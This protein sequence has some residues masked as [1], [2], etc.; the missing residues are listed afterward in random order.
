MRVQRRINLRGH[1]DCLISIDVET[2]A[3]GGVLEVGAVA[4]SRAD[5]AILGVHHTLARGVTPKDYSDA[6][7]GNSDSRDVDGGGV[8]DSGGGFDLLTFC[9]FEDID[10]HAVSKDQARIRLELRTFLTRF[11]GHALVQ[12]G[13]N[14]ATALGLRE[15]ESINA[16]NLFR[17]WLEGQAT[18]RKT[19]M[20]L[21][22]AVEQL[23]GPGRM[24][25]HRAFE[26]CVGTM[27]V[28]LAISD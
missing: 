24:M 1:P 19:N 2:S 10:D 5:G 4:F 28:L 20:K 16:L 7:D 22:E 23:L 17:V 25:P 13:G 14:D 11:P 21:G 9:G 12:W 3:D 27:I 26:D 18:Q 6:A 15:A 8:D